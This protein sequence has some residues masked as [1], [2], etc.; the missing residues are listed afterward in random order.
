MPF[1]S[2]ERHYRRL[3]RF[4]FRSSFVLWHLWING[5]LQVAILA[6]LTN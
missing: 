6:G 3:C 5:S 4:I 1:V 2:I